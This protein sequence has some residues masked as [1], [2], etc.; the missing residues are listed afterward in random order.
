VDFGQDS[1]VATSR[2]EEQDLWLVI[3]AIQGIPTDI[4]KGE[5]KLL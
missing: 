1:I 3:V 4:E 5:K 2:T